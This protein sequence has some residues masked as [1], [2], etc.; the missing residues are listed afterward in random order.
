MGMDPM[1]MSQAM[2]GGFGGQGMGMNGM[3]MGMGMSAAQGAFGGFTGQPESWI[4][5]QD[6]FNPNAYGGHANGM[7]ADFGNHVGY[8]GY[9]V[10]SQQGSFNQMHHQ[11]FPNND[12]QNGYNGQGFQNRGRGRRGAYYNTGRGRGGYNQVNQGNQGNQANYE[13]FHHQIPSQNVQQSISQQPQQHQPLMSSEQQPTESA[14]QEVDTA[15]V[16]TSQSADEQMN[17]ELNPGDEDDKAV[18]DTKFAQTD[19]IVPTTIELVESIPDA[20]PIL[21]TAEPVEQVKVDEITEA[22]PSPIETFISSDHELPGSNIV[23]EIPKDQNPMLP[24]PSPAIPLGP[25]AHYSQNHSQEFSVRGRGSIRGFYRGATDTRGGFR[26]RGAGPV[27]NGHNVYSNV[28]QSIPTSET[29][30]SI[31]AA[32][33]GLGVEGAP[34]GPK[35]FRDGLP[36]TGLRGGLVGGRGF[37]IVGRA[38]AAAQARPNGVTRSKR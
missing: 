3:N 24:P 6:K 32:L 22:K 37:S 33:K 25:A 23:D 9:N 20:P 7:G 19:T 1:A 8:G 14:K 35:A 4:T 16:V 34:K 38:S 11:Q 5:G 12:F 18:T 10:P 31:P 26:G 30:A 21:E 2:Y 27:P 36:N 15:E 17:K 28:A 29:S 13:P